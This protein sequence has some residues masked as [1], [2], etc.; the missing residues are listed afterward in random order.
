MIKIVEDAQIEPIHWGS[1]CKGMSAK[2]ELDDDAKCSAKIQWNLARMDAVRH[3]KAMVEIGTHKQVVNR[4]LEP[5]APIT[6]IC[7]ATDYQNFFNQR[8]HPDAQPEIR[9]LADKMKAAYDVSDPEQLDEGQWHIP[10]VS[11]G[12]KWDIYDRSGNDAIIKVAVGRCARTSYLNHDGVRSIEDDIALHDRLLNSKPA[13][14]SPFEHVA[15]AL[16]ESVK[17]ANFTGFESYRFQLEY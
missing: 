3:A 5:F 13:H 10:L 17:R 14:L 2:E 1:N 6:V 8:C 12:E 9:A 7:T 4:L 11:R 15:Q 16:D